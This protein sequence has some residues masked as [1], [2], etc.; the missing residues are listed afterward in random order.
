MSS[1]LLYSLVLNTSDIR[2]I[3]ALVLV[4]ECHPFGVLVIVRNPVQY[5]FL[6]VVVAAIAI[7]QNPPPGVVAPSIGLNPGRIACNNCVSTSAPISVLDYSTSTMSGSQP[8][9]LHQITLRDSKVLQMPVTPQEW[10]TTHS[11]PGGTSPEKLSLDFAERGTTARHD[12]EP[13]HNGMRSADGGHSHPTS[14]HRR[15]SWA[16]E[17]EEYSPNPPSLRPPVKPW[18]DDFA[19][20]AR[21]VGGDVDETGEVDCFRMVPLDEP[22]RSMIAK[23]LALL[24]GLPSMLIKSY[25]T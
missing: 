10:Q 16:K 17:A 12:H 20:M 22:G 4:P 18:V 7:Q 19:R 25:T 9:R 13:P 15:P 23:G 2:Q 5:H 21:K 8:D 1:I 24:M 14:S 11:R 6:I 3:S